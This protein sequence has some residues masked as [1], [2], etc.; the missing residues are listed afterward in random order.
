MGRAMEALQ[1]V[2]EISPSAVNS[3]PFLPCHTSSKTR[4]TQRRAG[5]F[6]LAANRLLREMLSELV[7]NREGLTLLGTSG[8]IEDGILARMAQAGDATCLFFLSDIST[9]ERFVDQIEP[10]RHACPRLRLLLAGMPTDATFFLV[11][12]AAG[13][14]GYVLE[15]ASTDE[16][17]ISVET[18]ARGEVV[19]PG[20]LLPVLF[21][22]VAGQGA[23]LWTA[24]SGNRFG[25]TRRESQLLPLVARGWTNKQIA[26]ELN[27]SEQTVKNHIRHML[28]KAGAANRRTLVERCRHAAVDS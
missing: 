17:M 12:V 13:A 9:P 5:I 22:S 28:R 10:L 8:V 4:G 24:G 11:A 26:L 19:C 25:L 3:S 15:N 2:I 6:V 7:A 1:D 23:T 20:S 18:V 16:V 27:L 14:V 21:R